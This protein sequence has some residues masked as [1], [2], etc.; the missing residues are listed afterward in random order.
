MAGLDVD[1]VEVDA[2]EASDLPS[3]EENEGP[4]VVGAFDRDASH[5]RVGGRLDADSIHRHLR[6]SEIE[7]HDRRP[8]TVAPALARRHRLQRWCF[9]DA[10]DGRAGDIRDPARPY[11]QV[12]IV[13][14]GEDG[15]RAPSVHGPANRVDLRRRERGVRAL[16]AGVAAEHLRLA[17]EL[18]IG[19]LEL[20]AVDHLGSRAAI[21]HDRDDVVEAP[22]CDELHGLRR[23][24]LGNRGCAPRH[25]GTAGIEDPEIGE[26]DARMGVH[27]TVRLEDDRAALADRERPR[28]PE[29]RR[30]D[31]ALET[32][33]D[34]RHDDRC[35]SRHAR[36]PAVRTRWY[37]YAP[38]SITI[39]TTMKER[40][41]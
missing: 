29:L 16:G 14:R 23:D 22:S 12:A 31:L 39:P 6:E 34:E 7:T 33:G 8:R 19:N 2:A 21:D 26:A 13:G 25:L 5:E 27:G 9:G 38:T 18:S 24:R 10:G 11:E 40:T 17:D 37:A 36:L 20:D 32:G 15:G 1:P 4:S 3:A 30:V 41:R 28:V 35:G